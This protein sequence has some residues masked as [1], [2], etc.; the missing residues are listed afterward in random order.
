MLSVMVSSQNHFFNKWIRI[1]LVKKLVRWE[2]FKCWKGHSLLFSLES[3]VYYLYLYKDITIKSI[4]LFWATRGV[5]PCLLESHL[6]V[7]LLQKIRG[8]AGNRTTRET[9]TSAEVQQAGLH[10]HL[11]AARGTAAGRMGHNRHTPGRHED[12]VYT[13][14]IPKIQPNRV[15]GLL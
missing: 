11:V 8:A 4:Y 13:V 7:F 6:S 5:T 1:Q 14:S 3:P 15:R 12:I 2:V 9:R 10:R